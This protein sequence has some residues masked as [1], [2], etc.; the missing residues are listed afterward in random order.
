MKLPK[1]F[2]VYQYDVAPDSEIPDDLFDI[3]DLIYGKITYPTFSGNY[4]VMRLT[5]T[6]SMV[7]YVDSFGFTVHG[8][9]HRYKSLTAY[10][11]HPNDAPAERIFYSPI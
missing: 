4:S 10:D 2:K 3:Y 8:M 11:D 7:T 6:P 5:K 1:N 9:G